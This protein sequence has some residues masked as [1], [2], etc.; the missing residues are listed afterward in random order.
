MNEQA[1]LINSLTEVVQLQQQKIAALE[2]RAGV[3][4]PADDPLPALA[5]RVTL[6]EE[7]LQVEQIKSDE[8]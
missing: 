6:L 3:I 5:E 7:V 2:R 8:S 4:A 1:L